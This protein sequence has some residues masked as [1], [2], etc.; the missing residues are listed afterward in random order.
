MAPLLGIV[1]SLIL[2]HGSTL[3]TLA[4]R[5][6]AVIGLIPDGSSFT[7]RT[8]DLPLLPEVR[9]FTR[10]LA[11]MYIYGEHIVFHINWRSAR[12]LDVTL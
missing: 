6:A 11:D 2:R 8:I 4:V 7:V 5:R 3:L 12:V 10:L 1:C 9:L